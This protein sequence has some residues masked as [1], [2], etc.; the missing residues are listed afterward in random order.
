MV[1]IKNVKFSVQ[2]IMFVLLMYGGVVGLSLTP[3]LLPVFV[4]HNLKN[5]TVTCAFGTLQHNLTLAW[6]LEYI[7]PFGTIS[8]FLLIPLIIGRFLC[9]WACPLGFVQDVLTRI[10]RGL[11]IKNREFSR[12]NHEALSDVKYGF[13]L[14]LI[15]TAISIGVVT[16]IDFDAGVL[17]KQHFPLTMSLEPNCPICP[18]P[19]L[20]FLMP[21]IITMLLGIGPYTNFYPSI[22]ALMMV[23]FFLATSFLVIRFWCRYICPASP[24]FSW[25]NKY[26][27]VYVEKDA[28]RCTRCGVCVRCCP[29]KSRKP[30]EEVEEQRATGTDCILCFCCVEKCPENALKAKIGKFT[31]LSGKH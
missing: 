14:F 22:P 27:L 11:K 7:I 9:G 30:L 6:E 19:A 15:F 17:Y 12:K 1:Q 25:C 23:S 5:R 31:L 8:A 16:I 13:C 20:F 28:N 24:L 3:I 29:S 18:A 2:T 26:S 21:D 4:D 10:R